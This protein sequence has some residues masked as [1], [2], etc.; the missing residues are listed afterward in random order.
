MSEALEAREITLTRCPCGRTPKLYHAGS[1]VF[2]LGCEREK[3]P[4]S[5]HITC[6]SLA[7]AIGKWNRSVPIFREVIEERT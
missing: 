6:S 1:G 4:R 5:C 3:C 7:G 2:V